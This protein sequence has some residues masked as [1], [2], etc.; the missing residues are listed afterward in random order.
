MGAIIAIDPGAISGA[1][2]LYHPATGFSVGDLPV[3][4]GQI[5]A[6]ELTRLVGEDWVT[7]AVVERVS[8]MPKQGVSSTFKFGFAAGVIFGVLAAENIPIRYVT[9]R[10]WKKYFKLNS[11]KEA[12][13]AL[14]IQR[15]PEVSGLQLKKYHGRAEAL[16]MLDW[17]KE[18]SK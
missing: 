10:E 5:D 6:A 17:Y 18:T 13:R 7:H 9:P 2:A 1:Y 11:E 14:A 16:L 4:N 8:A 12:A 15:H 3:V